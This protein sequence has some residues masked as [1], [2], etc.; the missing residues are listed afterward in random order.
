MKDST[1]RALRTILQVTIAVAAMLP[2]LLAAPGA[3]EAMPWLAGAA[4]IAGALSRVMSSQAVQR[5]LPG[6]LT[7]T[8]PPRPLTLPED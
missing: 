8:D 1:K 3:V 2:G 7:I 6:W 5:A 4:A